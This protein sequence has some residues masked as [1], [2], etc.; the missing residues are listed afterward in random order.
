MDTGLATVIAA[1]ISSL[2]GGV[3]VAIINAIANK[4][5]LFRI[6]KKISAVE[7]YY[8]DHAQAFPAITA[9]IKNQAEYC[10]KNGI[11]SP[12]FELKHIAVSM[13][14]SWPAFLTS[15]IPKLL[16]DE[17]YKNSIFKIE[18]AFVDPIALEGLLDTA[19]NDW[20][21]KSE[22]RLRDIP[23]F[24]EDMKKQFDAHFSFEFRIY[25][26]LPHWHGWLISTTINN[27][28][29]QHLFLGQTNWVFAE[30]N[31]S[32]YPRMTVGH[33]P[34]SYYTERT[35]EGKKR[36]QIFEQWHSYY[37]NSDTPTDR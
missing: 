8:P 16:S 37:F 7:D 34:Y 1:L 14:F 2:V 27:R 21:K 19:G 25:K 4:G 23:H 3:L 15:Q 36:I 20:A 29:I 5:A 32:D 35:I 12:V 18:A 28:R 9:C 11:E 22:D 33:N 13:S 10:K 26:N 6:E 30:K 24:I 17:D 31:A